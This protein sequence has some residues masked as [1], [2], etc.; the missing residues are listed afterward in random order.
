M[1]PSHIKINVESTNPLT[2]RHEDGGLVKTAV[3]SPCDWLTP[4]AHWPRCLGGVKDERLLMAYISLT[5]RTMSV[6]TNSL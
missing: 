3:V 2:W 4:A 1:N 6:I 5:C